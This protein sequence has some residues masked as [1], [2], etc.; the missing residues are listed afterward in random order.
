[1]QKAKSL[2][3]KAKNKFS[4]IS[5]LENLAA[6]LIKYTTLSSIFSRELKKLCDQIRINFTEEESGEVMSLSWLLPASEKVAIRR[7]VWL[8]NRINEDRLPEAR[9][10]AQR[11]W[12]WERNYP[13]ESP[14]QLIVGVAATSIPGLTLGKISKLTN[15][16]LI[17][18]KES[19]IKGK[20]DVAQLAVR[21]SQG[22]VSKSLESARGSI[23]NLEP[24]VVMWMYGDREVDFYRAKNKKIKEIKLELDKAG[25]V[26]EIITENNKPK[27]LALSPVVNVS[28]VKGNWNLEALK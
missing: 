6:A 26:S 25:V 15:M 18:S 3:V 21:A 22:I 10:A 24:E 23:D 16:A 14:R 9:A 12:E 7:A 4:E 28:A 1:M 17:L 27:A 19:K 2:P 8:V 13:Q 11:L 20:T 5:Y